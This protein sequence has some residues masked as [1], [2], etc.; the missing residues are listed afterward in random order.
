[1]SSKQKKPF[2]K[3]PWLLLPG[4]VVVSILGVF[5]Y[6]SFEEVD[7]Q[8]IQPIKFSHKTHVQNNNIACEYC[9]VYA[10]R[11]PHS[12]IPPVKT[13]IGCHQLIKGETA[14]QQKEIAKVVEYWDKKEPIPWKKMH[15]LPDFVYFSHKRHLKAGFDCTSCHGDVSKMTIPLPQDK[16]GEKALTMGW[17]MTC[18]RTE[19]PTK[20]GKLFLPERET[21]GSVETKKAVGKPDGHM[22]GPVDCTTCHK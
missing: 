15:D 18:H 11:S 5:L 14:E 17:C 13:C 7:P 9:H 2:Y 12:G 4:L 21:R 22:L 3:S 10:R 16:Y 8:E 19:H 6:L 1:M 20:D